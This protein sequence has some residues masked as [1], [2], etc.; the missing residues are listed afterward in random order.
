MTDRYRCHVR[1]RLRLRPDRWGSILSSAWVSSLWNPRITGGLHLI[2]KI[3]G[4][5]IFQDL[6]PLLP[7]D[8]REVLPRRR[9]WRLA[10]L[11]FSI[12]R[13]DIRRAGRRRRGREYRLRLIEH[14]LGHID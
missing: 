5:Q 4:I 11:L 8:I 13:L 2:L 6:L 3:F 10:L 14:L 12:G 9:R 7:V 1:T